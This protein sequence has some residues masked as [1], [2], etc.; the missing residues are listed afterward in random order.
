MAT[1]NR[2]NEN[3]KTGE[4]IDNR[5][6]KKGVK[7]DPVLSA[8]PILSHENVQ[9]I[10]PPKKPNNVEQEKTC[11]IMMPFGSNEEYSRDNVESNYVYNHIICPALEKVEAELGIKINTIREVDR[12]IAGSITKNILNNIAIA[13]ICIVDITGS[14][15]NVF[16]ELGIRYALKEKVTILMRQ[17]KTEIPFDISGYKCLVYDCFKPTA[18]I[19]D[20]YNFVVSGLTEEETIDSLVF[21]T[22]PEME[23]NIPGILSSVRK[24]DKGKEILHW[25]EWWARLQE[26]AGLL[27]EPFVNGRLSPQAIMGIS[28]GGLAVADFLGRQVFRGVPILAL[29]ANRWLED[30]SNVDSSCYFFDNEYNIAKMN[31]LKKKMPKLPKNRTPKRDQRMTIMLIDD[32]VYTSQTITQAEAFIKTQLG[33]ETNLLFTPLYCRN[34]DYLQSISH[35]LPYQFELK[36]GSTLKISKEEFFRSVTTTKTRLPYDKDIG[37][38]FL[39]TEMPD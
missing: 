1:E 23:V 31:I 8:C 20:V 28:N 36:D 22:F 16:F 3:K 11:F 4:A 39:R 14:N 38:E 18:A 13:D 19:E 7:P 24:K 17:A 37:G 5:P 35:M 30:T 26:L 27:K 32:L 34:T 15:P 33:P 21:E 9:A 29:W 25:D 6:L 10:F 12:N 2:S